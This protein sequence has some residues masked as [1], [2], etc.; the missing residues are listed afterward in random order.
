MSEKEKFLIIGGD[1]RQLYMADYLENLGYDVQI[2]A[3]PE[4]KRIC[5]RNINHDVKNAKNIILPLPVSKDGKYVYSTVHMKE[6]ID[7]LVTLFNDNHRIFAGMVS[8]TLKS[9]FERKRKISYY[10]RRQ[11]TVIYGRLS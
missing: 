2:Y 9:K 1:S 3:L 11:P 5:C 7:E 4:I 8:N 6:S 10:R